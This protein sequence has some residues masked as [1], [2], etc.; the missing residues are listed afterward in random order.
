MLRL[1]AIVGVLGFAALGADLKDAPESLRRAVELKSASGLGTVRA[2]YQFS[3]KSTRYPQ[4]RFFSFRSAGDVTCTQYR[5]DEEAVLY[6]DSDGNPITDRLESESVG[7]LLE[8]GVA[9]QRGSNDPYVGQTRDLR[10]LTELHHDIRQI[11][12]N[13]SYDELPLLHYMRDWPTNLEIS[14]TEEITSD[15]LRHVTQFVKGPRDNGRVEWWIDPQRDWSVVRSEAWSHG[16]RMTRI[17]LELAEFDGYWL[18]KKVQV[19]VGDDPAPRRTW[20]VLSAEVNRP[21]HPKTLS[22]A[23][24]GALPGM[25]I[26]PSAATQPARPQIWDGVARQDADVYLETAAPPDALSAMEFARLL[27]R[28]ELIASRTVDEESKESPGPQADS[29]PAIGSGAASPPLSEWEQ[30]TRDFVAHYRLDGEQSEKSWGIL[31]DC[32]EQAARIVGKLGKS[33]D[34]RATFLRLDAIFSERLKPRLLS[35]PTRAQLEA[36]PPFNPPTSRPAQR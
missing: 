5:G 14:Y 30:Y 1:L 35:L 4:H 12:L 7:V 13:P 36:V 26:T 33:Q 27:R 8:D 3:A 21:E 23:D 29:R 19:L 18:P 11:G 15:G 16:Q 2:E 31:R 34:R 6:R 10:M 25:G 28:A 17:D 22:L 20:E 9:Y 32:Q 24:I